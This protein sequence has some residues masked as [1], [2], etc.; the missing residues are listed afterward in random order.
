MN[1]SNA[2]LKKENFVERSDGYWM[3]LRTLAK[4]VG[5][6]KTN[7]AWT[8]YR[9]HEK[10]LTP[11]KGILSLGTPGGEQEQI[12]LNPIGCLIFAMLARTDEA[13]PFRRAI[14][15]FITKFEKDGLKALKRVDR[16]EKQLLEALKFKYYSTDQALH[17]RMENYI[18]LRKTLNFTKGKAIKAMFDDGITLDKISKYLDVPMDDVDYFTHMHKERNH[19]R[20]LSK[21]IRNV[22]NKKYGSALFPGTN[23]IAEVGNGNNI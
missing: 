11:F 19:Y 22:E 3:P 18:R 8:L 23:K 20:R 2:I 21:N 16:M 14:A 12:C 9:R 10:E 7:K 4:R 1:Q 5:Y 13:I 17:Y 15:E 6:R